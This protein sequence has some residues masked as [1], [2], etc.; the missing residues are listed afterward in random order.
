MDSIQIEVLE[1]G[2]IKS[3]IGKVG[4]QNHQSAEAFM[5]DMAKKTGG[6]V[7][8][9]AKGTPSHHQHHGESQHEH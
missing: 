7:T 8:R 1:D 6:K 9:K 5:T 3:T 2:T 4:A